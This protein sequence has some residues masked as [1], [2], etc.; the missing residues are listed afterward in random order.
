M[1][2]FAITAI[3]FSA[4]LLVACGGGGEGQAQESP[5]P[6]TVPVF[7]DQNVIAG[8]VVT[9]DGSGSYSN[10]K[11]SLTYSWRFNGLQPKDGIGKPKDST[12]ELSSTTSVKTSFRADVPGTYQIVLTVKDKS[13]SNSEL[14][15]VK[16]TEA[17]ANSAP[18][19]DA[20]I[21]QNV[22]T[23]TI[24]KLNGSGSSDANGDPLTYLW[25]IT[26]PAGSIATLTA[27]KTVTPSFNADVA[28][29]Y[30]INL[31]VNDGKVSSAFST[32]TVTATAPGT[33]AAPS[34]NAGAAQNVA[35]GTKVTLTGVGSSDANGDP[36]TYQ[37]NLTAKPVG[38]TAALTGATTV[39]PSFIAD[40]AGSYA[41]SLVVNDGKVNSTVSTVSVT[42]TVA[43][44]TSVPATVSLYLYSGDPTPVY[45]GCLN[46]GQSDTDSVCNNN[47]VYG[48]QYQMNSIWNK[49]GAYGSQ[50][51]SYSPW[52]KYSY[53]GPIIIGSDNLFYG[54]FTVNTFRFNRTPITSFL[55]VL[56]AYSS[57]GDLVSTRNFACRN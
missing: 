31:V 39:T 10:S 50:Y 2:L 7:K 20:G 21:A 57:S 55:N 19:A 23:G 51:S 54:Y 15:I 33:N 27:D 5:F 44:A 26:K 52:N 11:D 30:S 32:V 49:Y 36:L 29:V 35:M 24:V 18:I 34:A 9:L 22:V 53:S 12:A 4:F 40:L 3:M 8:T 38:S 41:L 25:S 45:L 16:A 56:N 46:C 37:W 47:G 43:A 13:G 48:D 17:Y 6:P 1:R 14:A 42:A 28:G